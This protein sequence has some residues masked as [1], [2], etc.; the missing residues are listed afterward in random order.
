VQIYSLLWETYQRATNWDGAPS[1]IR[2]HNVT[3]NST[4]TC[5]RALS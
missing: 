3:F 5:K 1:V 2:D 4:Q